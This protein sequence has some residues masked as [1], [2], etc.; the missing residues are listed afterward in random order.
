MLRTWTG[1]SVVRFRNCCSNNCPVHGRCGGGNHWYFYTRCPGSKSDQKVPNC[2]TAFVC[3]K[4]EL[5]THR[6]HAV[7]ATCVHQCS[8]V[9]A[10]HEVM[11][12]I[13]HTP[14]SLVVQWSACRGVVVRSHIDLVDSQVARCH[15]RQQLGRSRCLL[16]LTSAVGGAPLFHG[17]LALCMLWCWMADP[18]FSAAVVEVQAA[19]RQAE[20]QRRYAAVITLRCC[21]R[22]CIE[23]LNAIGT[24][25]HSLVTISGHRDASARH[26]RLEIEQA[27][28]SIPLIV[29][30][31]SHVVTVYF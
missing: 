29:L 4:H 20:P 2:D 31:L 12:G 11:F 24:A 1:S 14:H 13:L 3:S 22:S 16:W 21:S 23:N 28:G 27:L 9:A 10:Y 19:A 17:G 8:R 6:Q 15:C 25:V 5:A 7:H 30:Q 18:S 26:G